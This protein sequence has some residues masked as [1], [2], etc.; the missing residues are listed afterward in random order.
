LFHEGRNLIAVFCRNNGGGQAIDLGLTIFRGGSD[1][2]ATKARTSRD[3]DKFEVGAIWEGPRTHKDAVT[4]G[5]T[6]HVSLEVLQRMGP[7][8]VARLHFKGT[9]SE[10]D[11]LAVGTIGRDEL[12]LEEQTGHGHTFRSKGK[13]TS[14]GWQYDFRGRG[15]LGAERYGNGEMKHK[16]QEAGGGP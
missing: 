12:T 14:N 1:V 15:G 10:S 4:P 16:N 9:R 2:V 3:P 7:Q 11:T 13:L 5:E 6:G 8:I